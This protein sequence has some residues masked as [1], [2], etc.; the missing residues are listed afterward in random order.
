M[1]ETAIDEEGVIL[2]K[3]QMMS[4]GVSQS[5]FYMWRAIF[6]I[7]HADGHLSREEESLMDEYLRTVPFSLEQKA[8]LEDDI[9]HPKD[10]GEMLA[11]V[12]DHSDQ[13][14][15]F[16]FARVMCWSDGNYDVQE[17]E[18]MERLLG[19]H[20][21]RLDVDALTGALYDSREKAAALRQET[22]EQLQAGRERGGLG[23]MIAGL[24]SFH[25]GGAA[26]GGAV[27]DSRFY[28][29]R[30]VFAL[31][32]ADHTVTKDEREFMY[33]VLHSEAFSKEQRHILEDDILDPQD[34]TA[35]FMQIADQEDRS[36][37]F[38]YARMLCWC[39]G[40]FD[41]QE[42]EIVLKL[43]RLHVRNVNID[44]MMEHID[45]ALDD[46]DKDALAEDMRK[47]TNP[48]AAFFR[49]FGKS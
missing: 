26:A 49:R 25:R 42:Q 1:P 20:M 34:V 22:E 17:K 43:K 41:A 6:A 31:A 40:N 33:N 12:S 13:A 44:N 46:A 14:L 23:S 45:M 7:A 47:G 35:M 3:E 48:L 10:A 37:F 38:Y 8:I 18:I 28:M 9:I 19:A 15:F 24:F 16:Q 21:E 27:N 32:H 29:W 2:S 5:H 30:A 11:Q 4:T 36:R 39:D